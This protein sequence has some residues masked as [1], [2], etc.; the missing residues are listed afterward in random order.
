[1][2]K[3]ALILLCLFLFLQAENVWAQTGTNNAPSGDK[4]VGGQQNCDGLRDAANKLKSKYGGGHAGDIAVTGGMICPC[5][6]KPGLWLERVVYCF[7]NAPNGLIYMSTQDIM[8]KLAPYYWGMMGPII[9]FAMVLFGWKLTLGT[10]RSVP[11]ETFTFG[12][13]LG[14]VITFLAFFP[15]I[16]GLVLDMIQE[17]AGIVSDIFSNMGN[18][19]N[20]AAGNDTPTLWAQWDCIF[21]KLAGLS[22]EN[23]NSK[24]MGSG[25][26][27]G[28][29]GFIMAFAFLPGV[30]SAIV[31]L[32]FGIFFTLL[33]AAMR[34][35][36][37]YLMAVICA[38][39]LFLIA[40]LF[41]P[42]LL[43]G[44]SYQRF[45]S[46]FQIMI[47]YIL[48]PMML[49]MFLGIMTI[50]L[51]YAIFV[52]PNS[53]FGVFTNSSST[54]AQ[55]FTD[56]LI[57]GTDNGKKVNMVQ[58]FKNK[59]RV[60]AYYDTNPEVTP[61]K[62]GF[63]ESY[64][65]NDA[66]NT[67]LMGGMPTTDPNLKTSSTV[68]VGINTPNVDVDRF[69]E[70]SGKKDNAINPTLSTWEWTKR[71]I[72]QFFATLTL[73]YTLFVM[74]GHIPRIT[75]ELVARQTGPNIA[76]ANVL[77]LA[78]AQ[79]AIA[80]L[81]RAVQIYIAVKTGNKQA[82]VKAAKESYDNMVS[83]R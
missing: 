28:M 13:K 11:K 5:A 12:L 34:A 39:F 7:A 21:S 66:E 78:Q 36:N 2:K 16:H 46:W 65:Y 3:F 71:V 25:L 4:T 43:F 44:S 68:D 64:K 32:F 50:A 56:Q 54:K 69:V 76:N 22:V 35:V 9:L 37:T 72:L 79:R 31:L 74:L 57:Q 8:K 52:G 19:C 70:D 53:L 73:V 27:M 30:G 18:I 61:A 60:I 1:M 24:F 80:L 6:P 17:L 45:Y 14:G 10:L 51:E 47:G 75:H 23:K 41:V 29:M 63:S 82:L 58:H 81:R 67:G 62:P 40:P 59:D 83:K 33:A 77:G 48:Q 38:S 20:L 49:M 42:L 26:M 15:I 55:F